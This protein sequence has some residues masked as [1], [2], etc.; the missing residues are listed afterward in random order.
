MH[1]KEF[2][3][4]KAPA[5]KFIIY[6]NICNLTYGIGNLLVGFFYLVVRI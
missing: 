3:T 2:K 4:R 5:I 1:E 6:I